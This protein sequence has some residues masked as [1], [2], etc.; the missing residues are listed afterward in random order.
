MLM[1]LSYVSFTKLLV[2][3]LMCRYCYKFYIGQQVVRE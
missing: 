3:G 2:S 1:F